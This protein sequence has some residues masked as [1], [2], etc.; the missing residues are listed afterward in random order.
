MN[1]VFQMVIK[2]GVG[3]ERKEGTT[4]AEIGVT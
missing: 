4:A 2:K 3:G 1:T